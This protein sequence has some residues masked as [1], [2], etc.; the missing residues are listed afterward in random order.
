[1]NEELEFMS[2]DFWSNDKDNPGEAAKYGSMK[3]F[4]A[5]SLE[6]LKQINE[7]SDPSKQEE[8]VY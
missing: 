1:M 2:E 5:L 3:G 8:I 6:Y 4:T 7:L